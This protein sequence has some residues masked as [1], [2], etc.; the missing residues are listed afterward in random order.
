MGIRDKQL[1][2]A[3]DIRE[4][5]STWWTS[6]C[7]YQRGGH[8]GKLLRMMDIRF[9]NTYSSWRTSEIQLLLRVVDVRDMQLLS[10]V[11]IRENYSEW[12]ASEKSSYSLPKRGAKSEVS[13]PP[14][15]SFQS[16]CKVEDSWRIYT[17]VQ[18]FFRFRESWSGVFQYLLTWVCILG[19]HKIN[20]VTR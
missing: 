11:D 10:V 3:V 8:Q 9:R 16:F 13:T 12:W 19:Q 5:Y 17:S 2:S 14:D 15:H 6:I 1:L 18:I 7:S 4:S 20:S